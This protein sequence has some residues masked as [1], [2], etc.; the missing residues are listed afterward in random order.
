VHH[1]LGELHHH[2]DHQDEGD[3][4]QILQPQRRQQIL[5]DQVGAEDDRVSTKVV[6]SPMPM[7][8]SS[9]RETPM[10]GHRPR[11]FTSTKLFTSTVLTG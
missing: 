6:A 5:V 9:L 10:N 4:A 8:V 7:A 1:H 3:G 11:N 2:G